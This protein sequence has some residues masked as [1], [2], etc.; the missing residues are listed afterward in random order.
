MAKR[1]TQKS[2]V[3]FCEIFSAILKYVT[4]RIFLALTAHFN[5]ELH[6]MSVKTAFF[7]EILNMDVYIAQLEG[8]CDSEKSEQGI[9]TKVFSI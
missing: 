4:I 1:F 9:F 5:W 8:L 2:R 6:Y 7:H 3:N